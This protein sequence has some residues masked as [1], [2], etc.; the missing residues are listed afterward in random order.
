MKEEWKSSLHSTTV[1]VLLKRVDRDLHGGL[2]GPRDEAR[3]DDVSAGLED[4]FGR[5]V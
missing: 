1:V 2:A 5:E 3:E 4:G